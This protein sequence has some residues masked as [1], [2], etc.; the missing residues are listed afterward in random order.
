MKSSMTDRG[1]DGIRPEVCSPICGEIA[2]CNLEHFTSLAGVNKVIESLGHVTCWW[3]Q[4]GSLT[5][6]WLSR[7][8]AGR[9]LRVPVW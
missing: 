2:I 8:V 4:H 3:R 1:K 6:R 5:P 9:G 7:F